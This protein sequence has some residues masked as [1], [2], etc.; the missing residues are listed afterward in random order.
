M[1]T[2]ASTRAPRSV[3][4]I[5]LFWF[6]RLG[7]SVL[8]LILIFRVVPI[9]QVLNDARRLPPALW[10]G[11][12]VLFLAGHAAAAAKWRLLIGGGVSFAQAFRA[13]LAGLAANL[14]LPG[15]AGGDVVRAGLVYPFADDTSLLAVGSIADRGL[16]IF[17][18]LI[19][20]LAGAFLCLAQGQVEYHVL[21]WCLVALGIFYL[22]TYTFIRFLEKQ[23]VFIRL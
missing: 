15:L 2:S 18:L 17:G 5:P 19:L 3:R 22:T 9:Q 14:C 1:N 11:A 16:D 6:L 12:L 4:R 8:V 7:V 21:W 10:L 13:H 23:N 20:A